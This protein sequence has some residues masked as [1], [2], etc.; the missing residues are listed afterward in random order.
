M[1]LSMWIHQL[2]HNFL[3][4][5]GYERKDADVYIRAVSNEWSSVSK[6]HA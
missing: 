4:V 3:C 2:C 1:L 5:D 6:T